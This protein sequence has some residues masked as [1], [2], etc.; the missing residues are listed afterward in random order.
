MAV[1]IRSRKLLLYSGEDWVADFVDGRLA[2][3]RPWDGLDK[4]L[5]DE[6]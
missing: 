1:L 6:V 4:T 5:T 2:L 3:R